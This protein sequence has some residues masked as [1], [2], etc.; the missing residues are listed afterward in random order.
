MSDGSNSGGFVMTSTTT[1]ATRIARLALGFALAMIA[2]DAVA[3]TTVT[4]PPLEGTYWRAIELAGTPAPV[5]VTSREAHLVFGAG[6]RLTGSDGCNRLTGNY[7]LKGDALTFGQ[8][9][10]TQMACPD[11]GDT[12]RRFR[13]V[14]EGDEPL[15]HRRPATGALRRDGQ[16]ARGLRAAR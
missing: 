8:F 3:Q 14:I 2:A 6:T 4:T 11:T 9:A 7:D 12:D 16:T 5:E 1:R 10:V 15:P 13:A